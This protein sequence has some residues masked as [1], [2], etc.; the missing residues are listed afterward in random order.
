MRKLFNFVENFISLMASLFILILP[1]TTQTNSFMNQKKSIAK[2]TLFKRQNQN[3]LPK[4]MIYHSESTQPKIK[5]PFQSTIQNYTTKICSIF[6]EHK[7]TKVKTQ[8]LHPKNQP[9]PHQP[10]LALHIL[11]SCCKG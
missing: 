9:F 1:E 11:L 6:I 4:Y 8:K 5:T 7:I 2:I 3:T 10:R